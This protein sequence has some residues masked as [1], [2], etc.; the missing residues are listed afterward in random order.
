MEIKIYEITQNKP[1]IFNCEHCSIICKKKDD[2]NRHILT[3]KHI[4]HSGNTLENINS[5]KEFICKCG[6]KYNTNSGLWKH[7][8]LCNI[9][10]EN[11]E[12]IIIQDSSSNEIKI[13]TNLVL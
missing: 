4:K 11:T 2:W 5:A 8:K 10:I 12:N 13:L 6:K 3:K 7:N 9:S 1:K